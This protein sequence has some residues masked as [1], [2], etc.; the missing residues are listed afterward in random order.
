MRR[1]LATIGFAL[2]LLA[3]LAGPARASE[4]IT[5]YQVWLSVDGEGTLQVRE[6]IAYD[7][8]AAQRRGI[9]RDIPTTLRYDGTYDRRYPLSVEQVRVGGGS[10]RGW[11]DAPWTTES[12]PGG[13]TRIKIG[14]P[15]RTVTGVHTYEL[16][17]RVDGALNTFADHLE[18]Y[19][20]AIGTDWPAPIAAATVHARVP[21]TVLQV[22]CFA[23]PD[24]SGLPCDRARSSGPGATFSQ[25]DIVGSRL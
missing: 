13:M 5:S 9:Y 18:L 16:A 1:L 6:V 8:G 4:R 3:V 25:A 12:V 20:N 17:Y 21:G 2:I 11:S 24:R 23:G 7:F 10:A 19:W 22:A 14:D 15:D